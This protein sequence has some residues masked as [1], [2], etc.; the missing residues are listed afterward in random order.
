MTTFIKTKFKKSDDHTNIDNILF[1]VK[2]YVKMS[3]ISKF[4]WTYGLFVHNYLVAAL[5]ALDL[6]VF[7]IIIPRLTSI[8]QFLHT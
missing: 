3:K 7:G 1:H 6:T 2:I 4:K 5:S 8:G